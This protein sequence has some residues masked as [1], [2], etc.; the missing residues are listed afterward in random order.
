[1]NKTFVASPFLDVASA[2]PQIMW[3][4]DLLSNVISF[5]QAW[6]DYV[7]AEYAHYQWEELI[8]PLDLEGLKASWAQASVTGDDWCYNHRLRRYDGVF[9][10]FCA[11][12]RGLK[13]STGNL[14]G[15]LG[16]AMD[17]DDLFVENAKAI[18]SRDVFLGICSHELKT[19]VTSLKLQI[20][21]TLRQLSK[22]QYQISQQNVKETVTK[23]SNQV[24][25][26]AQL[27]EAMLDVS[28]IDSG[29]LLYR[30]GDVNLKDLGHDVCDRFSVH[31]K[32]LNV[33][34]TFDLKSDLIVHADRTRIEQVL[35][36]LLGNALKYG[37]GK[38]VDL[39]LEAVENYAVFRIT[40]QG[41]GI[42]QNHL[43]RIFNRFERANQ[44]VCITGLGLGLFICKTIMDAHQGKIEVESALG[45]GSTFSVFIPFKR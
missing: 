24:D 31:F 22:E 34:F 39:R 11:R 30:N 25:R 18:Q 15:W 21:L 9:K 38:P 40:D 7:G 13:D 19:P 4:W 10:W 23:L 8:H 17:I 33:P 29:K 14:I 16:S 36:N 26:M 6:G 35:V 42:S 1:M 37:A 32:E 28:R 5:N 45:R 20:Q 44:D 27:I 12:A 3:H 41:N 43:N 2:F